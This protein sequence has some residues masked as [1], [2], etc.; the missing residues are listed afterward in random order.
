MILK[1]YRMYLSFTLLSF[2]M[3]NHN[4]ICIFRVCIGNLK[5]IMPNNKIKKIVHL[6]RGDF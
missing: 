3:F 5:N 6:Y 4:K 1:L 2:K